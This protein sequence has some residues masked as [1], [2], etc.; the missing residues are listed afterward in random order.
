MDARLEM[1]EALFTPSLIQVLRQILLCVKAGKAALA[2]RI[3]KGVT[4]NFAQFGS[5]TERQNPPG[6]KRDFGRGAVVGRR[7]AS[8]CI[9]IPLVCARSSASLIGASV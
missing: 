5:L 6:V 7:C 9:I 3:G 8:S 1:G 4:G 2:D